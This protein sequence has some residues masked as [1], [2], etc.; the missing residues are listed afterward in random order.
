MQNMIRFENI[1]CFEWPRNSYE[2]MTIWGLHRDS[3]FGCS[4][5][6]E[7]VFVGTCPMTCMEGNNDWVRSMVDLVKWHR[8]QSF[9]PQ[10]Q[11]I[12]S[13]DSR[14]LLMYFELK[15]VQVML[16]SHLLGIR[17][18]FFQLLLFLSS[19]L[20]LSCLLFCFFVLSILSLARLSCTFAHE[21]RGLQYRDGGVYGQHQ[22]QHGE[23]QDSNVLDSII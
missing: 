12:S 17:C 18:V 14:W 5:F 13:M 15:P 23:T 4:D 21:S 22:H 19:N 7:F 3:S 9:S 20:L 11:H 10:N 8:P 2:P 6:H 1:Q 16:K